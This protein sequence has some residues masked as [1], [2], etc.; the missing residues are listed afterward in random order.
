MCAKTPLVARVSE[1][2]YGRDHC[3]V[4]LL[5]MKSMYACKVHNGF[6]YLSYTW[7]NPVSLHYLNKNFPL[8]LVQ[9][10]QYI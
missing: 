4:S 8:S 7:E 10:A 6:H 3:V 5:P 2:F 9:T 1:G